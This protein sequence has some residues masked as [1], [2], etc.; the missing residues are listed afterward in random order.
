MCGGGGAPPPRPPPP[1][2][3]R[4][5]PGKPR[6]RPPPPLPPPP[7]LFCCPPP[8]LGPPPA[9]SAALLVEDSL[10]IL[11]LRR[12]LALLLE[13]PEDED[14]DMRTWLRVSRGGGMGGLIWGSLCTLCSVRW[15]HASPLC[16]C[17][18]KHAAADDHDHLLRR[19]EREPAPGIPSRGFLSSTF[20]L[21]S[22]KQSCDLREQGKDTM[23]WNRHLGLAPEC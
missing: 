21:A 19:R 1:P 3:P 23:K 16:V 4:P 20:P 9:P 14:L 12:S 2:P 7:R 17:A 22:D 18:L 5:P 13:S 8:C 11:V 15:T 10:M 6:P